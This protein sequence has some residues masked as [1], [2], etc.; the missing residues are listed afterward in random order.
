[1]RASRARSTSRSAC[2]SCGL[3]W[4][5]APRCILPAPA[6]RNRE[7]C[8]P[9]SGS[10][11]TWCV[12]RGS[13]AA[14]RRG[15]A[16]CRRPAASSQGCAAPGSPEL[17]PAMP[18]AMGSCG[19]VQRHRKRLGQHFLHDP[20][21]IDRLVREIGPG[22]EDCFVEIGPGRGA[23]TRRLLSFDL[24]SLDAIEIDRDL[25]ALLRG[26][27]AADRRFVLHQGDALD[28][29]LEALASDRGRRLRLVGNLPYNVSTPL[30]FRFLA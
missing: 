2:R 26:E 21:V 24:A 20:A 11:P 30:L 22:G 7:A 15:L 25:A 6:A 28:F 23:L 1:M 29:D 18:D 17:C 27:L 10:P 12:R 8:L 5:T 3:P 9:Q 14:H 19:A 16:A 4:T 13:A